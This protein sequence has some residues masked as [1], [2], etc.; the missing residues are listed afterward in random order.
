[1]LG[2]NLKNENGVISKRNNMK[3]FVRHTR[4]K[5]KKQITQ[6]IKDIEKQ[7]HYLK[8]TGG[9]AYDIDFLLKEKAYLM[10][11]E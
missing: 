3:N 1:L 5:G 7:V 8:S 11:K 9:D 4:P 10:K 2:S 6:T